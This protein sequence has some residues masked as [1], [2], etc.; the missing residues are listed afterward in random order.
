MLEYTHYI[1]NFVAHIVHMRV[2][3]TLYYNI[4]HVHFASQ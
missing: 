1:Y 3:I 2:N 4:L